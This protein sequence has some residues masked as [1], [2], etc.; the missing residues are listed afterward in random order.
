MTKC[1]GLG[2]FW[3]SVISFLV[4]F[5]YVK[6]NCYFKDYLWKEAVITPVSVGSPTETMSEGEAHSHS[7]ASTVVEV[8]NYCMQWCSYTGLILAMELFSST[9]WS[10]DHEV[11]PKVT[12][13]GD[14]GLQQ[15]PT[16]WTL[17]SMI[18][19]PDRWE[20]IAVWIQVQTLSNSEWV[21]LQWNSKTIYWFKI[22]CH[23]PR[24]SWLTPCWAT[25]FVLF[26]S[27]FLSPPLPHPPGRCSLWAP[28]LAHVLHPEKV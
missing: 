2:S 13:P 1:H 11:K 23:G 18:C 24:V 4:F 19:K 12:E 6:W 9:A 25:C 3:P 27:L 5:Y 8:S 7:L 20:M 14:P 21:Y 16:C 28:P 26:L 10:W 22:H 17:S 15:R